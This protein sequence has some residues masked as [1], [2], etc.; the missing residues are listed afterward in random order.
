MKVTSLTHM[1]ERELN[2]WILRIAAILVVGLIAFGA[3]Y[4]FDRYRDP[5][6]SMVDRNLTALEEAVRADPDDV[7]AR[8]Q[9][10][11]TYYA[12]ARYEDAIAQ[13]DAIIA[14]GNELELAHFG[15]A[16][17]NQALGALEA[18]TADFL[19]VVDIAKGGEMAH[20]DPILNAAYFG[21]GAI[22]LEEGRPADAV[23]HL[24]AAVN[25]KRADADSLNLLGAALIQTG[26]PDRA[27]DV[28]KRAIAFVPIGWTEPYL[29]L[30][31][32]YQ[33]TDQPARAEW[34][35]AMADLSSGQPE[36]AEARLLSITEGDTALD[37]AIGLALVRETSGD[38]TAAAEWYRKALA[39]DP[40]NAEARLGLTRVAL[41]EATAA[42]LP[43]LPAPG[44]GDGGNG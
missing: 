9:L 22:A 14:S 18:A 15:R 2:R 35:L 12:A 27:I 40:E 10:A 24:T 17:A 21:L 37:A 34:A 28:L 19:V 30:A 6:P 31:E 39:I 44:Q 16:K 8:G 29:T 13:Y 33:A 38:T 41:P 42:P 26:D 7:V 25:I 23:E 4:F 1:P 20:V 43:E 5:G 3:F 36:Q 32:A 11:D